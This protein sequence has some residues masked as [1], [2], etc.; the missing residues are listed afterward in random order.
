MAYYGDNDNDPTVNRR[1]VA[2]R[3]ENMTDAQ[4]AGWRGIEDEK[5][6]GAY[7][8]PMGDDPN[9]WN[10]ADIVE[11]IQMGQDK[12]LYRGEPGN[13]TGTGYRSHDS[14]QKEQAYRDKMLRDSNL[15]VNGAGAEEDGI[16]WFNFGRWGEALK[17]TFNAA[18]L[19]LN[20]EQR[21]D[22]YRRVGESMGFS[23]KPSYRK[24]LPSEVADESAY[25]WS[26]E[27]DRDLYRKFDMYYPLSNEQ[28]KGFNPIDDSMM[29]ED[30]MGNT[31]VLQP[32]AN[33]YQDAVGNPMILPDNMSP[34]DIA[35]SVTPM[36]AAGTLKKGID[37][38]RRA[39]KAK[40]LGKSLKGVD[41]LSVKG[42]PRAYD[43]LDAL[44]NKATDY[45]KSGSQLMDDYIKNI[46]GG[47]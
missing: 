33:Q 16:D 46:F 41:W 8:N 9:A 34:L 45:A 43:Q 30:E 21:M 32:N 17:N 23:D 24:V 22:K 19:G 5:A 35:M 14:Y 25:D 18:G 6:S 42:K 4:L 29:W 37:I 12:H 3:E 39:L 36:G 38:G 40:G 1:N 31:S 15:P 2:F 7:A 10:V 28:F 26:D 44:Y 13:T 11:A 27:D 47:K 20:H